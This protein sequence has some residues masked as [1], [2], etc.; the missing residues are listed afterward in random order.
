MDVSERSD[1]PS[2]R[3]AGITLDRASE[4]TTERRVRFRECLIGAGWA[5]PENDWGNPVLVAE[6]V[7]AER[8][9][10]LVDD[11]LACIGKP[12]KG[13]ADQVRKA[14]IGATQDMAEFNREMERTQS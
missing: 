8:R 6:N 2:L 5:V 10:Q 12:S 1:L 9:P 7:S 11:Y 14:I 4:P 3:P 13:L